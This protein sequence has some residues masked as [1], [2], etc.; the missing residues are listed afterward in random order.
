[1]SRVL[2]D[3]E[4]CDL[5]LLHEK[6]LLPLRTYMTRSE[7]MT[8][9]NRPV[10]TKFPVPVVLPMAA[11]SVKV[12]DVL[13]LK[14][15]STLVN[16]DA[17]LIVSEVFDSTW[18]FEVCQMLE[19]DST[20]SVILPNPYNFMSLP[21][22]YVT[23][24]LKSM[25]DRFGDKVV[26]VT[27]ELS[28]KT[29]ELN[30]AFKPYYK[31]PEEIKSLHTNINNVVAFQTRNPL[32]QAHVALIRDVNINYSNTT[33]VL[34]PTLG[35]TQVEDIPI[36]YRLP[37]YLSVAKELQKSFANV[38]VSL[39]PIAMR[40]LG[41]R[42]ALWHALIRRNYGFTHFIV[43]RDHAGPSSKRPDGKPWYNPFAAINL[44][45]QVDMGIRIL[46]GTEM[47]Y[48]PES[49]TYERVT[50]QNRNALLS[51]SGTALRQALKDNQEVP[52]WFSYPDVLQILREFYKPGNRRGVCIQLTGLS[53]A[54]KSTLAEEFKRYIEQSDIYRQCVILDGDVLRAYFKDLGFDRQSRSTQTRR[55]G[56]ISSLLVQQGAIVVC[57]NIA[58][59]AEDRDANRQLMGDS[60]LEV[61][62][63]T[64]LQVCEERDVKGM[65]KKARAGEIKNFTGISDPFEA[66]ANP[67][68]VVS[69]Q[70]PLHKTL[71]QL[72]DFLKTK[73]LL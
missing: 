19:I 38:H 11:G 15:Q 33:L 54:G 27:G 43:G 16:V 59:Y 69:T 34:H 18:G 28:V 51:M 26:Y 68:L 2:N 67:D 41:P 20:D 63:D 8:S 66:P 65:Y 24:Y 29:C 7:Y 17:T 36:K 31:T 44:C 39:V 70:Q 62:V 12:G 10:S 32:H 21:H 13:A 30:A 56:F 4:C 42:E 5:F 57:A 53:G 25:V 72:I 46:T 23:Q 22:P 55:I 9:L 71:D 73:H 35:P 6:A 52:S 45:G 48:N 1:M 58:P 50:D 47:A 40:M 60:Y 3:Q 49:N 61:Y 64:S 37:C 14:S